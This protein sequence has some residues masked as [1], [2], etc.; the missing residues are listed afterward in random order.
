MCHITSARLAAR[1]K[2]KT[3]EHALFPGAM[4]TLDIQVNPCKEILIPSIY[5][6]YYLTIVDA[7]S[8][9]AVPIG[10]RKRN[11]REVVEALT[12]FITNYKP[13]PTFNVSD[14]L[15]VH[16]DSDP[17]FTSKELRE[18][19]E[20]YHIKLSFASPRHQHMNGINERWWQSLRNVAFGFL[21]DGQMPM[22]FF[23]F[24]LDHAWK[25]L[26]ALPSRALTTPDGKTRCPLAAYLG[27]DSVNIGQFRV[28]FCPVVMTNQDQIREKRKPVLQRRNNPERGQ[29]GIHVGI[30]RN[31]PGW[32]VYTPGTNNV[33]VSSDV[34]FDETF[35]SNLAFGPGRFPNGLPLAIVKTHPKEPMHYDTGLGA[36]FIRETDEGPVQAFAHLEDPSSTRAPDYAPSF[37]VAS[38]PFEEG[39]EEATDPFATPC[40]SELERLLASNSSSS[41]ESDSSSSTAESD[42]SPSTAGLEE[43]QHPP[44]KT[45]PHPSSSPPLRRSPRLAALPAAVSP[46]SVAA[47][48]EF[49]LDYLT[50]L[51][52]AY[53]AA[54]PEDIRGTDPAPFLPAPEHWKHFDRLPEHIRVHWIRSLRK[55]IGELL[56]KRTFDHSPEQPYDPSSDVLVPT[57]TKTRTKLD[58]AGLI[59]KLKCRICLRGDL[60]RGL[61]FEPDTWCAIAGH[62]ALRMFLAA[63]VHYRSRVWQL[64]YVG[65]FL[66]A[67]PI[68]RKFTSLPREWRNLFPE[69]K[70][71]FGVPLLLTKTLYGD[72]V[73]NLA[74]DETQNQWLTSE[75]IGFRRLVTEGSIYIKQEG[76]DILVLLNAVDDQLY[77]S[78]S[79]RLR[80]WFEKEVSN[81]FDVDLMGQAHWY[82][83]SRITQHE[84]F[85]ITL[86]QSRYAKL[87]AQRYLEPTIL[88]SLNDTEKEKYAAP[89]PVTSVFDKA[90]CSA[91]HLDVLDLQEEFKFEYA[92]VVGSLIYAMNTFA[93]LQFAIRKLARFMRLPGKKHFKIL[94]H[95]L[96][97]LAS[98][99]NSCGIKF[100]A[101]PEASPLHQHLR[102]LDLHNIC[103]YPIIA[104]SDSSFQDCPNTS[105][106]TGGYIVMIQGG[107]VDVASIVPNV[108]SNSSC[109]AEYTTAA[110]ANVSIQHIRKI[111]NEL[112]GH[113]V[114]AP[115]TVP[116]ALDSKSAIDT[117]SSPRETRNTRHIRRRVHFFRDSVQKAEILCFKVPGE[118]N[119]TNGLTKPLAAA[120]LNEEAQVYQITVS[121]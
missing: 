73:A 117:A 63:A 9:F 18:W 25:V 68:D 17:S 93:K 26:A 19:A 109:E 71:W 101:Q 62:K 30:P 61:F 69:W 99:P 88:A 100:Y 86:D 111:W 94:K 119:W 36:P 67:N 12:T 21:N 24:A 85:S 78:T 20:S 2:G 45:D 55:E 15:R 70:E 103:E 53:S 8:R 80:K 84:D 115:L 46:T 37:D 108:V 58:A 50:L 107:I 114:D 81:R 56:S 82:L 97:H 79:E 35:S 112:T 6:P 104:A 32:L 110:C 54:I 87:V 44:S 47:A 4:V 74:W 91:N 57:T 83:Q 64:D 42:S 49:D 41:D 22:S 90:D 95:L 116:F 52:L 66:Q 28:L 77:F 34:Y 11:A 102:A 40:G 118:K 120:Q 43:E 27:T 10:M 98:F 5:F 7:Y 31:Q 65:A 38:L 121:D 113:P 72:V 51:D 16:G 96:M 106:S 89:I 92:S 33:V 105:R 60:M 3:D 13:T 75:D 1:G 76:D 39:K 14:I 23:P 59:D 29:R 48:D